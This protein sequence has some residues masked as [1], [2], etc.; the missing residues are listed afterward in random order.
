MTTTILIPDPNE[1]ARAGRRR[2]SRGGRTPFRYRLRLY[3]QNPVVTIG[4]LA[5]M[6]FAYL[7]VA[8]IVSLLIDSAVVHRQDT[9]I[10]QQDEGTLTSYYLWR[11]F[12]SPQAVS[13]FWDPL[14][15]TL[16]IA[17]CSIV[18]A[19][20]IGISVA[21]LMVRTNMW[22]RKWFATALIVPYM[23]PAWTFALAW[24]TMFKNRTTGG[25]PGWL[26]N[27]GFTVPNWM[28]YGQFPIILIFAIH[29]SPFVILLVGNALKRFDATLE[30]SSRLLGASRVRTTFTIVLPILRP[31]LISAVT[32]ILAKVLGEFGVA[33][34][35]GL[36]VNMNV[37]ATSLY[38]NIY[39]DQSGSAAVLVAVIVLIG[40]I[41]LWVDMH[42]LREAKRFVT[43]S[44][45]SGASNA[46]T[47]LRSSRILATLS[48]T[49]LFLVS[50]AIPIL[51]LALSTVMRQ[52]GIFRSENFT[53][54]FW[55][56]RDLPTIGFPDGV[57]FNEEVWGAAWNSVWIVGLAATMAGIMGLIVGYVVVR[58]PSRFVSGALR[59]MVFF[60][61]LV[62]GIAFAVAYLSLFSVQRGPVPA[63]YGTA[64][65]LVLIYF[66]EQMPFA[67]RAGI[68]SMMQLGSDPE[69]AAQMSGAGWWRRFF[70][71]VLPIQKGALATGMVMAFISGI[72]S[73]SLVVILA[74][75]G[76]DVL[77]TLS[78]RLLD[79]GYSQAGNAVVLLVA[80]IAF[81][82][83]YS[84]QKIMKT[85][86]AQGIGG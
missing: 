5:L 18:L 4:V 20:V 52:P 48:C 77:T 25:Q 72:K 75:P 73:L 37:L 8:P 85:D 19:L 33:Y 62:P 80:A 23:L 27:L 14:G 13:I 82:G 65:I 39:S 32:L 83:T 22:G 10:T 34:V 67:S 7:I 70:T 44:G 11:V 47:E 2:K 81:I 68:S 31:A 66:T 76:M 28:S 3:A 49:V 58:S 64:A 30:E 29:F 54:A 16:L 56:G 69:E 26:E 15:N 86:L 6:L 71:V 17:V 55:T 79:I 46:V 21:W 50:V 74:V 60:P 42:F 38:R 35:L 40:A 51:V 1:R 24:V 63:L 78:I 36:P 84:V 53:L 43:I 41:S 12:A 59:Q 45:K 9:G 61:Y 57:L